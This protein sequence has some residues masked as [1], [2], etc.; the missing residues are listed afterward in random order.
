MNKVGRGKKRRGEEK[1]G[2]SK[3]IYIYNGCERGTLSAAPVLAF[4]SKSERLKIYIRSYHASLS[5]GKIN[6]GYLLCRSDL[7]KYWF[8]FYSEFGAS[9]GNHWAAD[10]TVSPTVSLTRQAATEPRWKTREHWDEGEEGEAE[11]GATHAHTHT[12]RVVYLA[13]K[14][15]TTTVCVE[16]F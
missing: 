6:R 4:W 5:R 1:K 10:F 3:K 16:M 11:G 15:T 14:L 8:S 9:V 12:H 2:G 7:W 13:M